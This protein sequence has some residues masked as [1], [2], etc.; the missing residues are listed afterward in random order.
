MRQEEKEGDAW[1]FLLRKVGEATCNMK[2]HINSGVGV[3]AFWR[4]ERH[5][6]LR[7]SNQVKFIL[8]ENKE[9]PPASILGRVWYGV[10]SRTWFA[11]LSVLLHKTR[12]T[13][14][15]CMVYEMEWR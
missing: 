9:A 8:R 5:E 15:C 3:G 13:L 11:G 6:E 10:S 12:C 14:V 7:S 2:Y 1:L 4:N